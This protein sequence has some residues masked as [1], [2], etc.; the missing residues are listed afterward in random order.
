MTL[1]QSLRRFFPLVTVLS[2]TAAARQVLVDFNNITTSAPLVAVDPTPAPA[3]GGLYYNNVLFP[4]ANGTGTTASGPI[5]IN[6]L[7]SLVLVDSSNVSSGWTVTLN[8]NNSSGAVG[9]AGSGANYAGP[10]PS[11][12][13]SF[14][15]TALKDGIYST[16]A[17]AV[18]MSSDTDATICYT[19]DGST[20][21]SGSS[22]YTGIIT[23]PVPST[24]T[25]KAIAT[26][27]GAPNSPVATATYLIDTP[28]AGPT[29]DVYLLGGQS[30]MQGLGLV[31]QL[32]PA[33]KTAPAKVFF[34]TNDSAFVPLVPGTTL[35]AGTSTNTSA[36]EFGPEIA[37][38]TEIAKLGRPAY[39]VKSYRSGTALD[40]GWSD[41]SWAGG[42]GPNRYNFH[43]GTSATDANRGLSYIAMVNTFTAALNAITSQGNTP[44]VKAL[45]WMQGEQ[46]SKHVVSAAAYAA[47]LKHLRDRLVQDLGLNALP[48]VI[49][50]A[51][52][53]GSLAGETPQTSTFPY[54][55]ELRAS[56][57]LADFKSG[58][59][60]AIRHAMMVSTDGYPVYDPAAGKGNYVHYNTAGQLTLGTAFA[61]AFEVLLDRPP[62]P[63]HISFHNSTATRDAMAPAAVPT[64]QGTRVNT[65]TDT[66]NN[67][68]NSAAYTFSNLAL[69]HADG[70]NSGAVLSGTTD[71]TGTNANGW[72]TKTKDSVMMDGWFGFAGSESL[73]VTGLPASLA[74]KFHVIVYGDANSARTMNYTIAGTTKT[75]QDTGTFDGT[76][77]EGGNYVIFSGLNGGS[78]VLTG[79]TASPRSAVNGISIIP[80]DPPMPP[81]IVSFTGADRYV[82]PG[83]P[84]MLS[85]NVT[86]A[87]SL[88]ISPVV[89]SVNGITGSANVTVA[90]TTTFTLTTTNSHGSSSSTVRIAVGPPRPNI[91]VFLVDDMGW[92]DTSV[93]FQFD[94][95]GNP[96]VTGFNHRYRTPHMEALAASGMRFTNAYSC[97]VCSPTR[98]SLLTGQ[99]AARHRVTQW[100]L[101]QNTDQSGVSTN[102]KSP[103]AWNVNGVA[104]ETDTVSQRV[105]RTAETLPRRLRQAGYRTIQTGKAHFGADGLPGEDPLNQG[106]DVNIGGHAA[107]GPGSY[108][109]TDNYGTGIHH[110]P[111]L[112]AYH[113]TD[114]FLTEALTLEAKKAIQQSVADGAPFYLYM[115]HYAIHVPL[116]LDSRFAENYPGVDATETKYASMIE[117][118]DKSLGDIRAKL[119]E[120]GVAKNTLILFYSD[121][122]GLS[123]AARG[124]T[125]DGTGTNTHNKP[126]RA[127]K[128]A[129]YEGGIRVPAIAG[130]AHPDTTNAFQQ[131]LPIAGNSRC[132]KPVIIEDIYPTVLEIAGVD[133]PTG[134]DGIGVTGYLKNDPTFRRPVSLLFHYPH[135]WSNSFIGMNQGYEMHSSLREDEWKIIHY[136][137]GSRWE[138]YNLAN[139]LGE[140]NNLAATRPDLVFQ[141]GRKMIHLL[142]DRNADYPANRTTELP[143]PPVL[144]NNITVDTDGDGAPDN[145]E[146][147]NRNGLVDPGETDP[148][149]ADTDGDGTADGAEI[150]TGTDPLNATSFFRATSTMS[151]DGVLS[152]AR[153][154]KPG[155]FYSIEASMDLATWPFRIVSGYP[156]AAGGSMTRYDVDTTHQ[157]G[158][159][160]R[161]GLEWGNSRNIC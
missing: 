29:V 23:L 133:V 9:P 6:G 155:A 101:Y 89:G 53:Y 140:A 52:P 107:G 65:A 77:T 2:A 86:G 15:A 98:V 93:P 49:G 61:T 90:E 137:E 39:L 56:Q 124:T 131:N 72:A 69:L 123:A 11:S 50:Q 88:S 14:A 157:A 99:S 32:T 33:Q 159:F 103:I 135:V 59:P 62:S 17:Q 112:D 51:L 12:V 41:Q 60:E 145:V 95:G 70:A 158:R 130:W 144:P 28:V 152:L 160:F 26:K 75:L 74:E 40:A 96:V 81:Q 42:L 68:Q 161:V 85:W 3:T 47:N 30:N 118:M 138:L 136:Y 57:A 134:I 117:G 5:P 7:S 154:S 113:G 66:W 19:T 150:K 102:L 38:A 55:S 31:A 116:A 4:Y 126:L 149:N 67:I 48:L 21:T 114:T 111:S 18:T 148:D 73:T 151:P 22:V 10:Y 13:N 122:G 115:A 20:S 156:A 108:L 92:Q 106:Y 128:G 83:T 119:E 16:A 37:F 109:G 54:R 82:A 63:I 34:W 132:D 80:G 84:V 45:L 153:P 110:V 43:A 104:P 87:E 79:N 125:P 71:Y 25:L 147:P 100:T 120:L 97:A 129:A 1:L 78:F 139:D 35:T 36:S 27:P 127:G 94:A 146:D 58:S 105:W 8:K 46:D 141:L 64:T 91:V 142:R 44:V 24:T 143:Q 121:N 76:F